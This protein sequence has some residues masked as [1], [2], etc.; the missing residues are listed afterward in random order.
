MALLHALDI[1]N[2]VLLV[3]GVM[4]PTAPGSLPRMVVNVRGPGAHAQCRDGRTFRSNGGGRKRLAPNRSQVERHHAAIARKSVALAGPIGASRLGQ[5][6]PREGK[7]EAVKGRTRRITRA[8]PL[9]LSIAVI[10]TCTKIADEIRVGLTAAW[11]SFGERA[12]G[13]LSPTKWSA[14]DIHPSPM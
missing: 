12:A 7:G 10:G 14:I 8:D 3:I 1:G 4:A 9:T 2:D 11:R 13:K 6:S 5:G